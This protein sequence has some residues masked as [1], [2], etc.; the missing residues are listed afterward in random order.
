MSDDEGP[1]SD[2]DESRLGDESPVPEINLAGPTFDPAV[3]V[4]ILEDDCRAYH[5]ITGDEGA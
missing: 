2:D 3:G 5:N 1:K 4:R